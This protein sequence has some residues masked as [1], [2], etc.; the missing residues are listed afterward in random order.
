MAAWSTRIEKFT[1]HPD[2][3][4]TRPPTTPNNHNALGTIE[5]FIPS[6]LIFEKYESQNVR[7][8][9]PKSKQKQ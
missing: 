4:I 9:S 6:P 8:S 5:A 3:H 1:T 7:K 2:H